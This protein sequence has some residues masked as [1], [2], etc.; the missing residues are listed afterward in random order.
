MKKSIHLIDSRISLVDFSGSSAL[1][2]DLPMIRAL[3]YFKVSFGSP[4]W[5]PTP[6]EMMNASFPT[7]SLIYAS[8]L[9]LVEGAT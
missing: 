1:Y 7:I 8:L 3:E 5:V 4:P 9:I 6:G 2:M